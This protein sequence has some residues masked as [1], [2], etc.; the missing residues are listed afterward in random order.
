MGRGAR[1]PHRAPEAHPRH[2]AAKARVLHR[3]RPDAG[4][5]RA[6]GAA[7]RHA[8]LGGARRLLL[9]EHGGRGLVHDRLFVLGIRRARLGSRKVLRALGRGRGPFE[10]SDQDRPRQAEAARREVRLDQSDP[11]RLFGDRRP[12]DPG[13][14]G[15]RR[16][17]RAVDHPRAALRR[18]DRLR[19]PRALHERALARDSRTRYA[20][21]TACS[22]AIAR[23]GRWSSTRRPARSPVRSRSIRVRRCSA[24]TCCRRAPMRGA[25]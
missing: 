20:P 8:E 14:A 6:V 12:V 19:V 24:A 1:D 9:G 4:A 3:P 10:Q 23:A 13:A 15:H 22:R 5:H 17:A 21:T 2:R 16:A 18:H 25:R 11:H 7:V